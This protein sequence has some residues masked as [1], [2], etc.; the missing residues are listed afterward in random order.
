[1][2]PGTRPVRADVPDYDVRTATDADLPELARMRIALRDFLGEC[3]PGIWE[4]SDEKAAH[5]ADFYADIIRKDTARV[6]VAA[7]PA[8]RPVAMLMVRI[9]ENA[10]I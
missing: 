9:L 1:V 7:D 3:S 4:L 10:N 5:L 6:F 2:T 8:G